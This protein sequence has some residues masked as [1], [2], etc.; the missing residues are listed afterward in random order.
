MQSAT[1]PFPEFTVGLGS[2][3]DK[4]PLRVIKLEWIGQ[5]QNAPAHRLTA[6]D[7]E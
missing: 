6:H 4:R 1:V 7:E 2:E 3:E 5:R